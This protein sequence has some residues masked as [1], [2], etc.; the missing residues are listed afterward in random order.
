MLYAVLFYARFYFKTQFYLEACSLSTK[1]ILLTHRESL[2][3]AHVFG[4]LDLPIRLLVNFNA[5]NRFLIQN[6]VRFSIIVNDFC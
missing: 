6:R 4:V 5:H 3:F 2:V 1:K